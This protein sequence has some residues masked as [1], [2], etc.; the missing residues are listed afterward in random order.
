MVIIDFYLLIYVVLWLFILIYIYICIFV[1]NCMI[2]KDYVFWEFIINFC[3]IENLQIMFK[4]CF[5][6]NGI[7]GYF[8]IY[9]LN[10]IVVLL[11]II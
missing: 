9:I 1:C 6:D 8:K 11:F 3:F 10:N 7:L 4:V 2:N 5:Y